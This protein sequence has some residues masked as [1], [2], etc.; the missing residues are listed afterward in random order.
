M[1]AAGIASGVMG[2]KGMSPTTRIV[3]SN[4]W[5]TVAFLAN[6][7]IFLIIG[8]QIDLNS[9][10]TNASAILWGILAVLIARAVTVYGL[11]L[12]NR[13]L[14][15]RWKNILFWGGLRG[16]ISLALV[17]SLSTAIPN[18]SQLQAMAFG[19]VLFTVVVE[20]L[21]MK[22]LIRWSKINTHKDLAH[23]E[24]EQIHA[25]EIAQQAVQN[26]LS[27]LNREGL[28]SQYTWDMVKPLLEKQLA[29]YHQKIQK[30]LDAEPQYHQEELADAWKEA[31]RVQRNTYSSL[32]RKQRLSEEVYTDL[33]VEIDTQLGDPQSTWSGLAS[34]ED[35]DQE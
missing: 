8:L 23:R 20:G 14:P 2:P 16:A 28:L 18:R 29:V 35:G 17:I 10:V 5:E 6:S 21:T 19:V 32:Y 3:V 30:V 9:L 33:I 12:I 15:W 31:L 11:S 7:F 27:R 25:R 1:V 13:D 26:H 34:L 24:Y 4:F 22:P